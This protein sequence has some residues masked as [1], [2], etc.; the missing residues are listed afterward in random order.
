MMCN[1]IGQIAY[2]D[3]VRNGLTRI[4]FGG[5]FIRGHPATMQRISYA[6]NFWSKGKIQVT[7]AHLLLMCHQ[8]FIN[9]AMFLNH[10]GYLGALGA[11]LHR[12]IPPQG[13]FICDSSL[14]D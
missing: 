14:L 12:H 2:M 4:Y 8:H 9:K 3:A 13:I 5:F 10:E 11:F 6:V 7:S 1:N